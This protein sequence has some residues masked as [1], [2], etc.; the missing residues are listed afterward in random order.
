MFKE[1][2]YPPSAYWEVTD[3]CNHECI[4]CFN[5]WRT[6]KSFVPCRK[7]EEEY[8][9]IAKKIAEQKPVK[10]VLTGGEPLT[11][12]SE[13]RSSIELF[14]SHNIGVS[15]NTN[16]A[17]VTE[18]IADYLAERNIL[19][20]ISFPSYKEE[21]FDKIVN[22]KGAFAQVNKALH[23]LKEKNVPFS[24]NMV[25]SKVNQN[26]IF[27]TAQL[28][29]EEYGQ[30]RMSI[31][32][33]SMPV[34]AIDH[35]DEYMLTK[36]ELEKYM[37]ECV[38][39]YE[40]LEMKIGAAS[41]FTPCSIPNQEAYDVFANKHACTAGKTSYVVSANGDVRAC[42]RDD[43]EYGNILKDDFVDIWR[44][45]GEWRDDSLIPK[46]CDGCSHRNKCQ[47]GCRTD[48]LPKGNC[49]NALDHYSD[50]SRASVEYVIHS[51]YLPRWT[52][53]TEF[54]VSDKM[55][56]V[57]EIEGARVSVDGN[58]IYCKNKLWK[59]LRDTKRFSVSDFC[60]A[61]ECDLYKGM[62]AL[63]ALRIKRI[64]N[65][66]RKWGRDNE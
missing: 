2:K 34:N 7:T 52:F 63:Y 12:F 24:V 41:P 22:R 16:A 54:S 8:L 33:V 65:T 30:K 32:R 59:Y 50:A 43:K 4:H 45:M 13:I 17:L 28:M 39:A 57:E 15:I 55:L 66:E 9:A 64:I 29:K 27:E 19:L 44:A 51:P 25:V 26:S 10:V 48:G 38:R 14:L 21:E 20:F 6:D 46:E 53:E 1:L 42:V 31:T 62:Q 49:R 56:I 11:V 61:F 3:F 47:G 58:F 35:F 18:E 5:Y 36:E 60:E 23:I 40:D 37:A